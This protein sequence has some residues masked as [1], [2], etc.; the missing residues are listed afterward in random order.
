MGGVVLV[1]VCSYIQYILNLFL[2]TFNLYFFFLQ[3]PSDGK[4]TEANKA[5]S[6]P[7]K[8]LIGMLAVIASSLSSGFAGVYYEKLLKESAQ[9]SVIIRNIQLGQKQK[10]YTASI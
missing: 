6:N 1:Q 8:H 10:S 9:P 7:H 3:F 2:L 4:Q 5:L